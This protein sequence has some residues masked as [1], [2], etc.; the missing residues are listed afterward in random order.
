MFHSFG[1]N[2]IIII[3][4]ILIIII[5]GVTALENPWSSFQATQQKESLYRTGVLT[6]CPNPEMEDQTIDWSHNFRRWISVKSISFH[7]GAPRDIDFARNLDFIEPTTD[8]TC[9]SRPETGPPPCLEANAL[10]TG[11]FGIALYI[12]YNLHAHQNVHLNSEK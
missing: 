4:T 8:F 12:V 1:I 7:L 10:T 2:I 3:I 9:T 11:F 6:L 5:I